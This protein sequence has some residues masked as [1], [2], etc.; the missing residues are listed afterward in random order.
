MLSPGQSSVKE[1]NFN[2]GGSVRSFR[3]ADSTGSSPNTRGRRVNS[4]GGGSD[5]GSRKSVRFER[6]HSLLK[7]NEDAKRWED[8]KRRE[9]EKTQTKE[10]VQQK[11]EIRKL[12][13]QLEKIQKETK[14]KDA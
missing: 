10:I 6:V 2:L 14:S 7:V 11:Q 3:Y 9:V 12:K 1:P 4:R 5:T 8:R 13:E